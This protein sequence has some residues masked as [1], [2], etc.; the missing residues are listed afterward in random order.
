MFLSRPPVTLAILVGP[1]QPFWDLSSLSV[2]AAV[3]FVTL[4]ITSYH[5]FSRPLVTLADLI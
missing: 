5:D 1:Q 2:T 4:D 3:L